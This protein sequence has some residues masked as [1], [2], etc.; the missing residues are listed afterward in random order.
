MTRII[1]KEVRVD[2]RDGNPVAFTFR[3]RY[4]IAEV[5]ECWQ[6]AGEWWQGQQTR[7][8]F[9]V[10]TSLGGVFELERSVGSDDWRLYKVWD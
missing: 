7:E 2:E 4:D 5:L 10:M 8:I 9:R 6:E 3:E 1:G